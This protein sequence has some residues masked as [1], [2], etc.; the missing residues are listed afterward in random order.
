MDL[1]TKTL[2][3]FPSYLVLSLICRTEDNF[4]SYL[5]PNKNSGASYI[6]LSPVTVLF[7]GLICSLHPALQ[8]SSFQNL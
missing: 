8:L 5:L 1:N 7:L 3:L 2:I 4:K 6:T